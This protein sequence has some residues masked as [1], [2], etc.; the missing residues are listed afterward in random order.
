MIIRFCF[1]LSLNYK[2]NN[3]AESNGI[4]PS[5]SHPQRDGFQDRLSTIAPCPPL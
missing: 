3:V 5:S 1:R 4:E 2:V